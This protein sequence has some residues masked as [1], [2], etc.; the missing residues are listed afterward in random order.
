[1][2]YKKTKESYKKENL[3]NYLI[4]VTN[5]DNIK[6]KNEIDNYVLHA[7]KFKR[8]DDFLDLIRNDTSKLK[9]DNKLK[10]YTE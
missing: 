4:N 9:Y 6:S 8:K 5:Q 3:K 7:Y 10:L 1:M 2:I